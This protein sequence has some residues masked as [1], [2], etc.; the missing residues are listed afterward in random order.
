MGDSTFA[1]VWEE[2]N[3]RQAVV[4]L[5]GSQ[6]PAS[7]PS[8][9]ASLGVPI[10]E[11]PN[12]TFKAASHLVV[13]GQ[14]KKYPNVK[15]ILAHAGGALPMLASRVAVLSSYMGCRLSPEE[16]LDGFKTFWYDVALSGDE[17]S[18]RALEAFVGIERML[19][20]TD[21]PGIFSQIPSV[22]NLMGIIAVSTGMADWFNR[23]LKLYYQ[24]NLTAIDNILKTNAT[25]LFSTDSDIVDKYNR[26]VVNANT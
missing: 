18:V 2:L 17:P 8:P 11:V 3:R 7:M 20:G 13:T 21:Y 16:I 23:H 9:D 26:A 1:P 24:H 6:I 19:F 4:F 10:T 12:Q 25:R 22:R 5:H 14:R 15:I